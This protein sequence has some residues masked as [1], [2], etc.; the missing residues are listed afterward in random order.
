MYSKLIDI[1]FEIFKYSD[2][3]EIKEKL[4]YLGNKIYNNF[5]LFIDFVD[6]I[7]SNKSKYNKLNEFIESYKKIN[8]NIILL[9]QITNFDYL[10]CDHLL[11]IYDSLELIN[12]KVHRKDFGFANN[13]DEIITPF[14]YSE[15]PI[16]GSEFNDIIINLLLTI[17]AYHIE[18]KITFY[19]LCKFLKFIIQK[20][21]KINVN[22]I[23]SNK[24]YL[25]IEKIFTKYN[26]PNILFKFNIELNEKN[27]YKLYDS[28]KN[29]NISDKID[30]ICE[31]NEIIIEY[32][33]KILHSYIYYYKL[34]LNISGI[35]LI[36]SNY[37]Y[38]L[39]G[40]T[41]TP[42]DR[43]NFIDINPLKII[44]KNNESTIIENSA[45]QNN[46]S[47]INYS[48][49]KINLK[50]FNEEFD[51]KQFVIDNL[52][53]QNKYNVIIDVG[54]IFINIDIKMLAQLLFSKFEYI[55]RF[56][57]LNKNDKLFFIN[58]NNINQNYNWDYSI[59]DDDL[60]FFDNSH[61]TG[62]DLTLPDN[63]KALIPIR[64]NTIYRDFIQGL[65]R[66][67]KINN[68]QKADIFILPN[69]F[70]NLNKFKNIL[71]ID[72]ILTEK[73]IK[74]NFTINQIIE[75]INLNENIYYNDQK[76]YFDLQQIRCIKSLYKNVNNLD[77]PFEIE[78][79]LVKLTNNFN[80]YIED[81]ILIDIQNIIAK[82]IYKQ[83]VFINKYII[84]DIKILQKFTNI[85]IDIFKSIKNNINITTQFQLQIEEQYQIKI[86]ISIQ[87][88]TVKFTSYGY[89]D[90]NFESNDL[91][92][93]KYNNYN[94]IDVLFYNNKYNIKFNIIYDLNINNL[95]EFLKKDNIY[96]Y[97]ISISSYLIH[98]NNKYFRYNDTNYIFLNSIIIY[99]KNANNKINLFKI[100]LLFGILN[101]SNYYKSI[102]QPY[103]IFD[104]FGNIIE[105]S[106]I[107]LDEVD[108]LIIQNFKYYFT[109]FN[110]DFNY[111]YYTSNCKSSIPN[112]NKIIN[113]DEINK[114]L[115]S[116]SAKMN[117]LLDIMSSTKQEN[118][119]ILG[120]NTIELLLLLIIKL[121]SFDKILNKDNLISEF[122]SNNFIEKNNLNLN[123]DFNKIINLIKNHTNNVIV[124]LLI[125]VNKNN[126][127]FIND[128]D[129]I[130][131]KKIEHI[132]FNNVN[133][134]I[135]KILNKKKVWEVDN[136][137]DLKSSILVYKKIINLLKSYKDLSVIK[138][139]LELDN[140]NDDN[141]DVRVIVKLFI[142]FINSI[143][144][145]NN[146]LI[147]NIQR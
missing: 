104:L 25:F 5:S 94:N 134:C 76:I 45:I 50:I 64:Q 46:C 42:E 79:V 1:L 10:F 60:I 41:G 95:S 33:K 39:S 22:K 127:Y 37:F 28:F 91:N 63:F 55:N 139:L 77:N 75:I 52:N 78:N 115:Y 27:V 49:D 132:N 74:T 126:N 47:I 35:D 68:S 105:N 13:K 140:Y 21:S 81:K 6:Y 53:N 116:D 87:Q 71:K 123:D 7:K 122:I 36:N 19:K 88:Q 124:N 142:N 18:K 130:N 97:K 58:R 98:F 138:L 15:T 44:K 9:E 4:I 34:Q 136:T 51:Y 103:I 89:N 17:K 143:Q 82:Y 20:L 111:Y 14:Q 112:F 40:F 117:T 38:Y 16:I 84:K 48:F 133:K 2:I 110:Y 144:N 147:D 29:L 90:N 62:I 12:D 120:C 8:P 54:S 26:L 69:L 31:D 121:L 129:I 128:C 141:N 86:N 23:L 73:I 57:Y 125:N 137:K 3:N 96:K 100:D 101:I 119:N 102:S 99:V 146:I 83:D 24:Y 67:R 61:I 80:E 11:N 106:N 70:N 108:K 107:L 92:I 43:F 59:F 114:I 113:Y 135:E 30:K 109:N 145:S 65:Y 93:E 66:M 131:V 85:L 72:N 56:I 32:C 118:Y